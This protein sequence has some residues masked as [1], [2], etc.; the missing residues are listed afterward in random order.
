MLKDHGYN[1]EVTPHIK[2]VPSKPSPIKQMGRFRHEAVA[3]DE[4]SGA[5]YQTEDRKDGM[6]YRYLPNNKTRLLKAGS[7][8]H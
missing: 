4:K 1:F 5:V 3:F 2:N 8:K 7:F 6:I